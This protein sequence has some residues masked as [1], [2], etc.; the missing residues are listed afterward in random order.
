MF[1]HFLVLAYLWAYWHLIRQHYGFMVLYRRKA[2]ESQDNLD[3]AFLWIG[4]LYPFL[5]F[6]FGDAYIRSGLPS[7]IPADWFG[8]ARIVLDIAFAV[9]MLGLLGYRL[10]QQCERPLRIGPKH[11]FLIIVVGFHILV[12]RLLDNL[13]VITATLTIFHNLQY[14][15]VVWQYERGH[16]RMPMGSLRRYLGIGIFFG[17]LW[18]GPRTIGVAVAE[19]DLLRNIL[20]GLGWG[21][22]FHHYCVDARIWRVRR[23]PEVARALDVGAR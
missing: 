11:L 21:V 20:L 2:G 8:G 7:V 17:L 22:A 13:L 19:T 9:S 4:S 23:T 10:A 16:G 14:H 15:R 12:F 5:Y 6:S 3:T 18:Y 1:R